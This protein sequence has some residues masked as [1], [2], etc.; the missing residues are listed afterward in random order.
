MDPSQVLQGKQRF[1]IHVKTNARKTE[2]LGYDEAGDFFTVA[3]KA[4]P[5]EGRANEEIE[6]Y[7]SKL[8]GKK[9]AIKTGHTG[10]R[11]LLEIRP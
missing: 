2:L 6:R 4:P 11:K 9:V 8:L 7:F 1:L 5:V 3:V 10:K